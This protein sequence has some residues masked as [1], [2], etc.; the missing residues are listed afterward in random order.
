MKRPT[1]LST[2]TSIAIA[3]TVLGA[4]SLPEAHASF[5][6]GTNSQGNQDVT[7]NASDVGLSFTANWLCSANTNCGNSANT[8]AAPQKLSAT[9]TFTLDSYTSNELTLSA[10]VKNTT[11]S[12]FQAALMSI[13]ISAP[14]LKPSWGTPGKVFTQ[15]GAANGKTE[16]FP[17]GFKGINV[18][19]SSDGCQGSSINDGLGD[20]YKGLAPTTDSF[21]FMLTANSGTIGT[22]TT[23]S[24]FS[25]KFQTSAG[26]YEFGDGLGPTPSATPE[27][28]T[29]WL[30]GSGLL[31]LVALRLRKQSP[32]II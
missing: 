31:A 5:V 14:G 7:M 24:D 1:I 19:I 25:V 21:S 11:A 32:Q 4:V 20:G 22:E 3:G 2:L 16:N 13:G 9:G 12:S 30:L 15:I 8:T 17:G 6:F 10:T 27:P 29:F 28:S 26:S 23:L 18:C